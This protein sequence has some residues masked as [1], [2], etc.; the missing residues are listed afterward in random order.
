MI[1][2]E[3][4]PTGADPQTQP[5]KLDKG[6]PVADEIFEFGG[7]LLAMSKICTHGMEKYYRGS[8]IEVPDAINRYKAAAA[9]HLFKMRTEP[10][11]PDSGLPH[12]D[13]AIWNLMAA[14]ELEL[15]KE[16]A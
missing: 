6:K 11:D 4:D 12:I 13:H 9:R 3:A 5:A 10:N 1:P 8:W 16:N 7:A 2:L 15:R 14:R